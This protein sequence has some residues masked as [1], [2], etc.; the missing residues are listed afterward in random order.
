MVR[1]RANFN[2]I[3]KQI[4]FTNLKHDKIKKKIIQ[5]IPIL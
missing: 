4:Y 3:S 2:N 5:N 1:N